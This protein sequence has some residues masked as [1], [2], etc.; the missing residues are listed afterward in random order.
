[1]ELFIFPELLYSLTLANIISP[2][3]WQW[4]DD[5]WFAGLEKMNTNKRLQRLKQFIMDKYVFNL[6]L[7]TW[8]LTTKERELARFK[9]FID[10]DILKQSNALFGYEGDKYYFDIDIRRHFGLDKFTSDV[11]PYW[12]TETVEAMNAFKHKKPYSTGAGEC[13]SLSTLYAAALFIICK[14]PLKDIFMMATPLHS[15]NFVMIKDGILTNNRRVVTK[16]MW[17]NG[18]EISAKARRAIEN[19]KITIVSHESGTIHIMYPE[20]TISPDAYALFCDKLRHFTIN[21]ITPQLLSNFVR[22]RRDLQKCFQ[23]KW[24]VRGH[25]QYIEAE[26]VFS[27]E[28]D[29]PHSFTAQTR[30]NLMSEIDVDSFH[31][32]PLPSRIVLNELEEYISTHQISFDHPESVAKLRKQFS[33]DCLSAD[34]ALQNLIEFCKVE[35]RLPDASAKTF[36]KIGTP[37]G[38]TTEM[39]REEIIKRLESIRD[40]N[41]IADLAF[42]SYRDLSRTEPEP[43]IKASIERNPVCLEGLRNKEA[44]EV[45][46]LIDVMPNESIYADQG[47]LAQPDEVWNYGRGDGVE[48]ALLLANYLCSRGHTRVCP[49]NV[50]AP[51]DTHVC[52]PTQITIEIK[53]DQAILSSKDIIKSFAT[54]KGLRDQTWNM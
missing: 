25:Q 53:A 21:D 27:Y 13:V 46:A 45:I 44:D 32:S 12:K 16:S 36:K 52:V 10:M 6:D 2:C 5:P 39:T 49:A 34:I 23:V 37:L 41:L 28:L 22:F 42:Y 9:D 1:M 38:I 19:E 50:N 8:G 31:A 17:V 4:R 33:G 48:K 14:I 47:R 51:G 7:E 15:Q 35:P 43:F 29:S 3:I 26:R 18:S 40:N 30:K 24:E 54:S 20:A 11:I